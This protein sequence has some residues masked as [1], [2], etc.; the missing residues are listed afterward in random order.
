MSTLHITKYA[1]GRRE[2]TITV[3]ASLVGMAKALLPEAALV[4]LAAKGIDIR[5]IAGAMRQGAAYS[6]SLDVREHGVDK[7]VVVSLS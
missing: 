1:A 2:R 3:P 7:R 4:A 6:T 5:A